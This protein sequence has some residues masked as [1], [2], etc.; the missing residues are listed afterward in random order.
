MKV[1]VKL[2]K[3]SDTGAEVEVGEWLVRE[4]EAV[5]EGQALVSVET[6]KAV[7]EVPSPFS[8]TVLQLRAAR[9]DVLPVGAPL[10]ELEC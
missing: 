10:C 4:G 2:P 3:L 1:M 7:V 8:G 6:D 5:H 9:G